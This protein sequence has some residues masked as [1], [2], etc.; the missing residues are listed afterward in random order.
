M[1]T[2]K[3]KA[4]GNENPLHKDAMRLEELRKLA[5]KDPVGAQDGAW[6]WLSE[7]KSL[8]AHGHL[9]WLFS[10]GVAPESP[11]GDCLGM[12]LGLY[13]T[14]WLDLV[15]RLSRIGQVLGGI[16][17][18]GK[19]FDPETGTGY[20]RLTSSSRLAAFLTM[21]R[22]RF[23]TIHGELTGFRFDHKI[24]R[25]P[26]LPGQKVRSIVYANPK[27]KNP[28]VLPSTR[29]E[30]VE[31]IPKVYLGRVLLSGSG[32]WRLVGFFALRQPAT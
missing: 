8:D 4:T 14:W 26:L 13:G 1:A 2:S 18:T 19:T 15:D 7:F 21:P 3:T 5:K 32:R 25:S 27:H 6:D 22:Y 23:E 16:G 29:D 20:N 17:W 10:E 31:I 9:P 24:D 30:I 28:L 12:V 11:Q